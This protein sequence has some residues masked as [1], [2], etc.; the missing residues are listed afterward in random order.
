MHPVA[1]T[2]LHTIYLPT[3][4]RFCTSVAWMARV[5]A[6]THARLD[7]MHTTLLPP[8]PEMGTSRSRREIMMPIHQGPKNP[9]V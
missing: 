9:Y 3:L 1:L 4:Q 5:G 8:H 2:E 7:S 6:H